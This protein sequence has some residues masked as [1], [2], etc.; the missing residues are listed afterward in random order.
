MGRHCCVWNGHSVS[1]ARRGKTEDFTVLQLSWVLLI[2]PQYC[3]HKIPWCPIFSTLWMTATK[4][5]YPWT[6]DFKGLFA[7]LVPRRRQSVRHPRGLR[8]L[9]HPDRP[10]AHGSLHV[11]AARTGGRGCHREQ[12]LRRGRVSDQYAPLSAWYR[13]RL[14]PT[15]LD[16]FFISK[17][18]GW[19][20]PGIFWYRP[21]RGPSKL[22]R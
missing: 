14:D 2:W 12:T 11:H 6:S 20:L 3:Q 21:G 13:S 9:R 18:C 15:R 10:L 17:S 16:W 4:T 8:G 5:L 19:S 1:H 22:R 7:F